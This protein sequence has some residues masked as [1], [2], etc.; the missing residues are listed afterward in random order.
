MKRA[1]FA[2]GKPKPKS[3]PMFCD[4]CGSA[5]IATNM[6]VGW[7]VWEGGEETQHEDRCRACG[8]SRLWADVLDWEH[9]PDVTWYKFEKFGDE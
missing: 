5:D 6:N 4:V 3:R 2:S 7:D 1:E 9:G 8:A